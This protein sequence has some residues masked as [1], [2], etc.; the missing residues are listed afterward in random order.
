[1]AKASPAYP[2]FLLI[3]PPQSGADTLKAALKTSPAVWFPPLDNILAFHPSFQLVRFLT[4]KKMI[5]REIPFP[6]LNLRWLMRYFFRLAPSLKWYGTLFQTK[7]EGLIKGEFSDEYSTLPYDG[8]EKMHRIIPNAK[9]VLMVRNPIDRSYADIRKRFANHPTMP[10]SSM[11]K[12]QLVA[13]MNNDWAITH[14]GVQNALDSWNVFF[15]RDQMFIGFYEDL[16][17]NPHSFYQKLFAF[18]GLPPDTPVPEIQEPLTPAFPADLY[19]FLRPFY[20]LEIEGIAKRL[21]GPAK[22]WTLPPLPEP[23]KVVPTN[24]PPTL[25]NGPRRLSARPVAK[26]PE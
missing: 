12:R 7:E 19:K 11:T 13:A 2:D 21:G 17:I 9:I 25:K 4:L 23:K 16:V 14:S 20:R 26:S 18:L 15:P 1:M 8:A 10:F 24:A 22:K 5:K 3:G 6:L